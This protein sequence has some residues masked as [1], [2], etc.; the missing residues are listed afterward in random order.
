[1]LHGKRDRRQDAHVHCI[2]GLVDSKAMKLDDEI[3]ILHDTTTAIRP[4]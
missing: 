4:K 3:N 2:Y 1:M